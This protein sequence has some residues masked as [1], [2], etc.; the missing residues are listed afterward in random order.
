[1]GKGNGCL[2]NLMCEGQKHKIGSD[3]GRIS[4]SLLGTAQDKGFHYC[5][6]MNRMFPYL[7]VNLEECK[8]LVGVWPMK[9]QIENLTCYSNVK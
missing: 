2:R 6:L 3:T 5:L 8:Y 1:M 4:L 7:K 9:S